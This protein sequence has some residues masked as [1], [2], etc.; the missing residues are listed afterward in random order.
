MLTVFCSCGIVSHTLNFGGYTMKKTT[1]TKFEKIIV[2]ATKAAKEAGDKWIAE[3]TKPVFAVYNA[4]L[5]TGKAYGKCLGTMLDC[6]GFA[7][8]LVKDKRT[9]FAKW[10]K[11]VQPSWDGGYNG[12]VRIND[13]H[14]GRQE[15]SLNEARMYAAYKV[16]TDAGIKGIEVYSRID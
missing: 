5:I 12:A 2:D 3:H 11:T 14:S 6:C 4:D 10:L 16:L 9:A 15:W 7:S 13:K 1:N 8:I